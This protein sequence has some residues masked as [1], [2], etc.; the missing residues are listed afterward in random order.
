M[1]DSP[2]AFTA[3]ASSSGG[4]GSAPKLEH[5]FLEVRDPPK[6]GSTQ[7]GGPRGRVDFQFN[8]KEL[9]VSK[10]A[11]WKRES[12]RNKKSSSVPEFSGSDPVKLVLDMFLDA[13]DAMDSSVVKAVEA[14]FAL[15]VP[16]KESLSAGKACPPV[17]IFRWGGLTG[18]VAYV[19][20]VQVTYSLFT[21]SGTPVRAT[22]QVS[23]EELTPDYP[24]Q[25]P[26]SGSDRVRSTHRVV[27][28]DSLAALAHREYGDAGLWRDIAAANGMDDPMRLLPGTTLLLPAA[29]DLVSKAVTRA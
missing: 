26:T 14:L 23:L 6:S 11:K 12:Q 22:A 20:Q 27:E 4:M 8:P 10:S 19:S 28:G 24:P 5:A 25:N 21:P 15:V 9:K 3:T 2:V 18:F 13:S 16:T 1:A 17:V 29:D 7:P